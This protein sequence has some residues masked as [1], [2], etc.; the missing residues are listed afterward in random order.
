LKW[1]VS[2]KFLLDLEA[3]ADGGLQIKSTFD[4]PHVSKAQQQISTLGNYCDYTRNAFDVAMSNLSTLQQ[5]LA[6]D[7]EG[8]QG[9]V[10]PAGGVFFFKN[11]IIGHEGDLICSVAY[12]K[13]QPK[14]MFDPEDN[15]AINEDGKERATYDVGD[16]QPAP[17]PASGGGFK[18]K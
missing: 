9:L 14:V 2:W 6:E 18:V 16:E 17:D 10:L 11:P 8:K 7:L 13:V 12:S 1:T 5:S 3:V 15:T 4:G